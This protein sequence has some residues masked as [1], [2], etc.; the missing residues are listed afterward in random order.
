MGLIVVV[1]SPSSP[2]KGYVGRRTNIDMRQYLELLSAH[3]RIE[4]L[5]DVH[6]AIERRDGSDITVRPDDD[7]GADFRIDAIS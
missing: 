2:Q 7:H 4:I 5:V 1:T 3:E 6:Q